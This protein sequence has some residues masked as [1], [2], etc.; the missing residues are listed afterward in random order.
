MLPKRLFLFRFHTGSIKRAGGL[1]WLAFPWTFR[2]HTGSI[3]SNR[4]RQPDFTNA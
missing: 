3:K 1:S 4:P 2:F